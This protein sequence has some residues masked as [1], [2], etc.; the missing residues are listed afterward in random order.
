M[1]ISLRSL[2]P[3]TIALLNMA[4]LHKISA[5]H[6]KGTCRPRRKVNVLIAAVLIVADSK[7]GIAEPTAELNACEQQAIRF[8]KARAKVY[9]AEL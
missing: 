5:M 7:I 2:W 1:K 8:S 9:V 3:E 6:F 4:R